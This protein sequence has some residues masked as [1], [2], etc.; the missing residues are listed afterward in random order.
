MTGRNTIVIKESHQGS[1]GALLATGIDFACLRL[2]RRFHESPS[3]TIPDCRVKLGRAENGVV[4]ISVGET[5]GDDHD[6][7]LDIVFLHNLGHEICDGFAIDFDN[8][9]R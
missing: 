5:N 9:L 2:V 1:F 7:V 8:G 3:Q 4:E 6:C